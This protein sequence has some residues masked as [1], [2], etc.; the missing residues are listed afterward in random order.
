MVPILQTP[1]QC[2]LP[3]L[4]ETHRTDTRDDLT[5]ACKNPDPSEPPAPSDNGPRNCKWPYENSQTS[6]GFGL[7]F[8]YVVGLVKGNLS[9]EFQ[10]PRKLS[11]E[12]G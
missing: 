3:G 5:R 4:Y 11:L 6:G 9:L 2:K 10:T 8:K 12:M 1:P 7:K